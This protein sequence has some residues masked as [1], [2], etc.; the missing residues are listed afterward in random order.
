MAHYHFEQE[1]C[2][3]TA[4]EDLA[5]D[6]G[7]FTLSGVSA[8]PNCLRDQFVRRM[9]Q[10]LNVSISPQSTVGRSL[11]ALLSYSSRSRL[12]KQEELVRIEQILA[13]IATHTRGMYRLSARLSQY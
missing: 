2:D 12:T 5:S 4:V 7:N 13:S 9:S 8:V 1:S 6:S 3:T 11:D 10:T